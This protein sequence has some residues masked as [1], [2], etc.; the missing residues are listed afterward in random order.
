MNEQSGRAIIPVGRIVPVRSGVRA[1]GSV[2]Y[3]GRRDCHHQRRGVHP[4]CSRSGRAR[5]C[6]PRRVAARALALLT[7]ARKD[8]ALHAAA[9]AVLASADAILAANSEDLALAEASGTPPSQL[10]RLRLT[11]DRIDGIA[12]GLRQVASLP[13][14][15]GEL[16]E[17][18]TLP[19]GLE[20]RQLAVPLGVVGMIYEA[21]P[22][23]T[24]DAFGLTLKSGNAVL[25]RGRPPP[26]DRTPRW[27]AF[28]G[29]PCRRWTFPSTPSNSCPARIARR[30]RTSSG[31]ADSSTSSS[32]AVGPAS[33]RRWCA[34]RRCPPSRPV[35]ATATSTC[36]R[37][38]TSTWPSASCSMRRHV[39]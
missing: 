13:D 39:E 3:P 15:V 1:G 21:R 5:R 28:C 7:T 37:P 8:D 33:S 23:V 17:G 14:P 30:S 24:V 12:A 11:P 36:T 38:R 29:R 10:D 18:R 2:T 6:C 19:N 26:R 25:L 34:T 22:N 20:I 16:L 32:R 35:S 9:D 4:R 27:W 31:L